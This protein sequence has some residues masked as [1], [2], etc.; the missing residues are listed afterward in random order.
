MPDPER[1]SIPNQ[2]EPQQTTALLRRLRADG[3]QS[4]DERADAARQLLH[5]LYGELRALAGSFFRGQA[6]SHTLQPT[7]LVHEAWLRMID[8]TSMDVRDRA[9]FLA[10]AGTAMRHILVDHARAKSAAKRGGARERVQIETDWGHLEPAS[11]EDPADVV[12]LDDA[13]SRLAELDG[14]QAR[15]VEMRVFAGMTVDETAEALGVSPRTVDLDW[16]MARAW[17]SR[18]LNAQD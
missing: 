14:R 15:I 18:E 16:R 10:L 2:A 4:E 1:P 7:A 8:S 5:F 12:A 9:H 17:L 6:A 13:L 11:G 3:S